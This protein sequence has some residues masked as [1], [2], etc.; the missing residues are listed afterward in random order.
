VKESAV[1]RSAFTLIE[2]M[3]AIA[4]AS[5]VVTAATVATVSIYRSTL[6]L[7]QASF[8]NEEAKVVVDTLGTTLLQVG[9]GQIRPWSGVSNGCFL[10][11]DGTMAS[12]NGS[13]CN[14]QGGTRLD[15]VDLAERGKQVRLSAL[16]AGLATVDLLATEACP[17]TPENGYPASGVNVVIVPP[18]ETGAGWVQARCTPDTTACACQLAPLGGVPIIVTGPVLPTAAGAVMA[19]GQ[20]LSYELD[21]ASHSLFERQ[22]VD[23]DG[24]VERRLLSDRVFDFRVLFG[25]DAEPEDGVL[26]GTWQTAIDTRPEG[27]TQRRAPTLRMARVGVVIGARVTAKDDAGGSASL[28]GNP[29]VTSRDYLLRAAETAVTMR[30]L[31]VF[32]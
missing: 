6:A 27:S 14:G 9:G 10:A 11:P 18:Q 5:I 21:V 1:R 3:V 13:V 17:L 7:E 4:I 26:D 8:A 22:D 2:L 29:P 30:N 15:L 12:H 16:A 25:Y 24:T 20:T 23:D 19:P 32:F 31:L 28:F